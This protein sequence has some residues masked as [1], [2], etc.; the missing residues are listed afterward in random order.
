MKTNRFIFAIATLVAISLIFVSCS[1]DDDNDNGGGGEKSH[2]LIGGW[3]D[4]DSDN[5]AQFCY[6]FEEDGTALSVE[7]QNPEDAD[8]D[9]DVMLTDWS[10]SKGRITF[11]RGVCKES[12]DFFF[13]S[14]GKRINITDEDGDS[15]TLTRL[16]ESELQTV[17]AK[18]NLDPDLVGFWK[19]ET[20][21][22]F[23]E[24]DPDGHGTQ[25]ILSGL[26]YF[27]ALKWETKDGVVSFKTFKNATAKRSYTVADDKSYFMFGTLKYE[28][29]TEQEYKKQFNAFNKTVS[30]VKAWELQTPWTSDFASSIMNPVYRNYYVVFNA[31]GTFFVVALK[32]KDSKGANITEVKKYEGKWQFDRSLFTYT[33]NKNDQ[34][35]AVPWRLQQGFLMCGLPFY[36]SMIAYDKY[37]GNGD[38]AETDIDKVQQYIEGY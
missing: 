15:Q 22:G 28:R 37:W 19:N 32:V 24:L 35:G 26:D 17:R 23:V 8:P 1:K 34:Y 31:D 2:S 3:M 14:D 21:T 7:I 10:E 27:T 20:G 38:F 36:A 6:I 9:V 13:S 12:V 4:D 16:T 29:I 33:I 30:I 11:T 18:L 25:L 5:N